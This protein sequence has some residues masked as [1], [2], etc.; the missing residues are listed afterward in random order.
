MILQKTKKKPINSPKSLTTNLQ[1]TINLNFLR[2][3]GKDMRSLRIENFFL[4]KQNK[5]KQ[6][7][8][9]KKKKKG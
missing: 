4:E 1:S 2:V 9:K 3:K 6:K 8:K 5:T 7:K